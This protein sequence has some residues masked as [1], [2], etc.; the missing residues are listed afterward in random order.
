MDREY[1]IAKRVYTAL[2]IS[3]ASGI[4]A[5]SA[6]INHIPISF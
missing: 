6:Y 3:L 5:A 4:L 1:K 2:V